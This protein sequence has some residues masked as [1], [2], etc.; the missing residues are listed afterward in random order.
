MASAGPGWPDRPRASRPGQPGPGRPGRPA[1][2]QPASLPP[3]HRA[4]LPDRRGQPRLS[5]PGPPPARP[6]GCRGL[7]PGPVGACARTGRLFTSQPP[8]AGARAARCRRVARRRCAGRC[9]RVRRAAPGSWQRQHGHQRDRQRLDH[10]R[11]VVAELMMADG[12]LAAARRQPERLGP[13]A[14][15]RRDLRQRVAVERRAPSAGRLSQLQGSARRR[16]RRTRDGHRAGPQGH[17]GPVR[18]YDPRPGWH[19]G[20]PPQGEGWGGGDRPQAGHAVQEPGQARVDRGREKHEADVELRQGLALIIGLAAARGH[21]G[22]H[23]IVQGVLSGG[24][25]QQVRFAQRRADAALERIAQ[26]AARRA[27]DQRA[28]LQPAG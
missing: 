1:T 6:G 10:Q 3:G 28:Q 9:R 27:Q 18:R 25:R 24:D 8:A 11:D 7:P 14:S 4:G 17:H 16:S 26:L 15:R 12:H 13:R 20:Q 21:Q 22:G 2:E 5:R 19:V 23:R